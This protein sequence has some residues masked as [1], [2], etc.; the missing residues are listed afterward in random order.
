MKL[1]QTEYCHNCDKHVVFEFDDTTERQ[2]ILCP[3]CNH[4]HW[5][6]LD[7]GTLLDIQIDQTRGRG[8]FVRVAEIPEI[9]ICSLLEENSVPSHVPLAF[10]EYEIQGQ[11][12]DSRA[13]VKGTNGEKTKFVSERRWG[14]DPNQRRV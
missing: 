6:E 11:A 8:Q 14:V 7:E 1:R 5:R 13:I 4:Q 10:K 12:A 9:D 2:V 3:N